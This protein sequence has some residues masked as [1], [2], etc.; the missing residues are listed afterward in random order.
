MLYDKSRPDFREMSNVFRGEGKEVDK[1][2]FTVFLR[3]WQL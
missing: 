1:W 2:K 3:I